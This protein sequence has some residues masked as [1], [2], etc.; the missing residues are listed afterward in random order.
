MREFLR[1]WRRKVGCVTLVMACMA[2][3]LWYRGQFAADNI[4]IG[5]HRRTALEAEL[6]TGAVAIGFRSLDATIEE[7]ASLTDKFFDWYVLPPV[8][9]RF[10]LLPTMRRDV[11]SRTGF[12]G[13]MT[14]G[15]CFYVTI[16][17]MPAT[18]SLTLLS[19]YLILW[20]PRKRKAESDA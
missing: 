10:P 12:M 20:K 15:P 2:I 9:T 13:P 6:G 7:E 4:A 19:A 1:G 16:P 5:I 14:F 18:L 11:W 17:L 3:A 8:E